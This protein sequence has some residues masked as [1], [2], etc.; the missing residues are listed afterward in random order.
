MT[1][2]KTLHA[3]NLGEI[4]GLRQFSQPLMNRRL[5]RKLGRQSGRSIGARQFQVACTIAARFALD[6]D[7]AAGQF[8]ERFRQQV[9]FRQIE[10]QQNFRR[11]GA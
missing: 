4:Q 5:L 3:I 2:V 8:G 9:F 6:L 1:D 11:Q 10:V 7:L